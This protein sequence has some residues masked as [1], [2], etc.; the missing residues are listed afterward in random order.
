DIAPLPQLR[1]VCDAHGALLMVDEAHALGVIGTAGRGIE[2]HFGHTVKADIKIG[3]LSKAIPSNGGWLAGT[4]DFIEHLKR[5]ARPFLCSAALAPGQAGAAL[6]ALRILKLE[7]QRVAHTQRESTR[8]RRIL[9]E[10]GMR[11]GESETAV[12]PLIVGSDETAWEYATA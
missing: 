8:L 10:A 7:P 1:E 12:I 5:R 2:D 11:T 6:E 3:T 9:T 4:R